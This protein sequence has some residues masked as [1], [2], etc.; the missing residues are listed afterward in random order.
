MEGECSET[1]NAKSWAYAPTSGLDAV[2]WKAAVRF[3]GLCNALNDS[4]EPGHQSQAVIYEWHQCLE[5]E[6]EATLKVQSSK[7]KSGIAGVLMTLY[8]NHSSQ[9]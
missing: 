5:M 2:A 3:L 9:S 7:F 1:T 4:S 8:R 6:K